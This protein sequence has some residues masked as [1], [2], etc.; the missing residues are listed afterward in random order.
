MSKLPKLEIRKPAGYPNV[1]ILDF[2]Q[3]REYLELLWS[4]GSA[5]VVTV[6]GQMLDS[7]EKLVELA[8]QDCYKDRE[9][10]KVDVW[11]IVGGG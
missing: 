11:P 6:E 7:Y 1:E 10:L 9:F 8:N 3:A 2:E 4:Y 5:V